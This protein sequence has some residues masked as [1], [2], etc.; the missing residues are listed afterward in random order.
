MQASSGR[1]AGGRGGLGGH[2]MHWQAG[3]AG[4]QRLQGAPPLAPLLL[5]PTHHV[6]SK[7][8]PQMR[9]VDL[10]RPRHAVRVPL[11]PPHAASAAGSAHL[12]MRGC[13]RRQCRR[14]KLRASPVLPSH[15][16]TCSCP[17]S[18]YCELWSLEGK[19]PTVVHQVQ[20][21]SCCRWQQRSCCSC[22]CRCC[23][24]TGKR[25]A[26]FRSSSK[27]LG[28]RSRRAELPVPMPCRALRRRTSLAAEARPPRHRSQTAHGCRAAA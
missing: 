17:L 8:H 7:E 2:G 20:R 16:R 6:V 9:R 12:C 18:T 23:C 21:R 3:R 10:V 27:Q 5:L 26:A 25:G 24:S 28:D 1:L 19:E 13:S 4:R 11:H 15:C 22:C 14:R